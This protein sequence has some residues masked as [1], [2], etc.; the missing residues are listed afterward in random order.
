MLPLFKDMYGLKGSV[1]A[2]VDLIKGIGTF[3][4]MNIINVPGATGFIDTNFEG[5]AEYAV[6]A[7]N[8]C[9]YVFL[10]VEALMSGTHGQHRGKS[11]RSGEYKQQ[12][13]SHPAGRTSLLRR[14]PD[15]GYA[16]HPRPLKSVPTSMSLFRR[17]YTAPAW[18]PT[19]MSS[20]M[21]LSSPLSS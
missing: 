15:S 7:F 3:A 11:A 2:A 21:S 10:H 9:D 16:D 20:I 1:I 5:K 19:L 4:G 8:E 14:L 18:K 6:K 12:N 17:L 13:A